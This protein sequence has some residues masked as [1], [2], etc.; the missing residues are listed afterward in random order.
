MAWLVIIVTPYAL[1]WLTSH[2]GVQRMLYT[3]ELS[4][5]PRHLAWLTTLSSQ[6]GWHD[7]VQSP[8][9][10]TIGV[11]TFPSI[12]FRSS[13]TCFD[14]FIFFVNLKQSIYISLSFDFKFLN[15]CYKMSMAHF[16]CISHRTTFSFEIKIFP[17]CYI[18]VL[19]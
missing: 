1:A 17:W 6:S 18:W 7:T 13:C 14:F 12:S 10:S 2:A 19:G 11:T 4:R 5:G 8:H 9:P 16:I 15:R 3:W